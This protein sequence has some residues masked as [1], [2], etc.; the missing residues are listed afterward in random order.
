M[1]LTNTTSS[2]NVGV[3]AYALQSNT[4]GGNN[5]GIGNYAMRSNTTYST[6]IAIGNYA[7]EKTTGDSNVSIGQSSMQTN[8]EGMNNVAYEDVAV[9]YK[10]MESVYGANGYGFNVA[11]GAYALQSAT[12]VSSCVASG[13]SSLRCNVTGNDN[14]AHG[15]LAL[16]SNTTGS[17]NTA[18]GYSAMFNNATGSVN[19]AHGYMALSN[20]T[21]SEN[22]GV[23]AYSLTLNTTGSNNTASGFSALRS[24]VTGNL[25]TAHGY[26][27]LLNTTSSEN[28]GVGAYALQSNT[29]GGQNTALG[30]AALQLT[31]A[32]GAFD[33]YSNC[34]GLGYDARVSASD[35]VQL[36]NSATTTYIYGA[37]N[38]RSDARD[39]TD[40]RD[41]VLGLD[42][43]SKLRPVDY[44]W[45]MRDDY[46]GTV[47][48]L[49]TI[50]AGPMEATEGEAGT[51]D[52]LVDGRVSARITYP[53]GLV[54]LVDSVVHDSGD[55]IATCPA[56]PLLEFKVK[57]RTEMKLLPKDGSKKRNRYHH[58]LI[59]QEVEIVLQ[60]TGIDFGGLQH[61]SVGGGEDIYTIGYSELFGPLIK[62]VQ[63]LS[64]ENSTLRA[65]VAEL[66]AE[67]IDIKA[68][69]AEIKMRLG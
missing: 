37:I 15:C 31:Q 33:T 43:V 32:G 56:L 8:N 60:E 69:I 36:G 61:H 5:I 65:N 53:G 67:N 4:T 50:E 49:E 39:K 9:G 6:N 19:T 52:I 22:V 41:T 1:A 23:G 47:T 17:Q 16:T 10:A 2:E 57:T 34:T 42:F 20:T 46:F 59:A 18:S 25:N 28:V 11:I 35:Q 68:D 55:L 38:N 7:L 45:D 3:G 54:D 63:Q 40:V 21:S 24:N 27:A 58:G 51:Y 62:A 66:K 64:A 48:I 30:Y 26:M 44:K 12:D 13:Y 29:T 14:S